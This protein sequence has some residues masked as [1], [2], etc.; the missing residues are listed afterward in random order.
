MANDMSGKRARLRGPWV[1]F[2]VVAAL[3]AGG[4]VWGV[5]SQEPPGGTAAVA[6]PTPSWTTPTPQPTTFETPTP[7]PTVE[8]SK[9]PTDAEVP[10]DQAAPPVDGVVVQV[11]GLTAGTFSGTVPGEPS[12]D[13][14]IV[15]VRIANTSD[16]AVDT[17][18]VGVNLTYGGDDRTPAI[19]VADKAARVLPASLP[20]GGEATADFTFVAPLAAEGDIRVTVDLLASLPDVVFV[21]PRP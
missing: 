1:V 18:G 14:I 4:V 10:L 20:A 15:A 12:G 2:G 16:A 7:G 17:S 8:V 11:V 21:G 3:L 6:S 13:S 9:P 5:L 19:A